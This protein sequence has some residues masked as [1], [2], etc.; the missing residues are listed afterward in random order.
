MVV[1]FLKQVNKAQNAQKGLN[2]SRFKDEKGNL[3]DPDYN[4]KSPLFFVIPFFFLV[5]LEI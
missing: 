2:A 1:W 5:E 4:L 3:K